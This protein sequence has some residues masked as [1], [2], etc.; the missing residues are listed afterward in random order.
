[1]TGRY[2]SIRPLRSPV[3]ET[4]YQRLFPFVFQNL[5][6]CFIAPCFGVSFVYSVK[7]F[8][9]TSPVCF[10][11][12]L[13][14]LP[15]FL[16]RTVCLVFPP[17]RCGNLFT[18]GCRAFFLFIYLGYLLPMPCRVFVCLQRSKQNKNNGDGISR[19]GLF[20]YFLDRRVI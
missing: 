20:L 2:A 16:S 1:M 14:P 4:I 18:K 3:A 13:L 9:A 11:I 15:P 8:F 5:G 12:F 17:V 6:L 10:I 19:A 7:I